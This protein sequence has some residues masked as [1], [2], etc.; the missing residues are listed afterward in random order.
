M[1]LPAMLQPVAVD[2]H[3][4]TGRLEKNQTPTEEE[5]TY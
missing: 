4:R 1:S 5:T 3:Q 2:S